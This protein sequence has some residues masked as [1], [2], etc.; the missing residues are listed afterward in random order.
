M[1]DTQ[2]GFRGGFGTRDALFTIQVLVQRCQDMDKDVF[3][4]FIDYEKAFD[5]VRHQ[6]MLVLLQRIG[7]DNREIRIIAN[8]YWKHR[9]NVRVGDALSEEVSIKRGVRQGCVLSPMLFN[10][11]S[12]AI[13]SEAL[14]GF[15]R[16]IIVNG[17]VIIIICGTQMTRPW[18][19]VVLTTCKHC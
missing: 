6:P 3:L 16:G 7:L 15:D 1:T 17:E 9:A 14:D 5:R 18:L 10:I 13:L 2:F 8:L 4:C 12:E 11:Y 19:R